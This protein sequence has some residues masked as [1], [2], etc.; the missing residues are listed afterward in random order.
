MKRRNLP[1]ASVVAGPWGSHSLLGC[2]ESRHLELR[3]RA[4]PG[5][6]VFVVEK[7]LVV[8]VSDKQESRMT[9]SH[10][11]QVLEGHLTVRRHTVRWQGS[12][13]LWASEAPGCHILCPGKMWQG[14]WRACGS[15]VPGNLHVGLGESLFLSGTASEWACWN[16]LVADTLPL[17]NEMPYWD[18]VYH[19]PSEGKFL[20]KTKICFSH[21]CHWA[22]ISENS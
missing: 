17:D 18:A 14:H 11:N 5:A 7:S 20:L 22:V 12:Q 4:Q 9:L 19:S 10:E 1:A 15:D 21:N 16:D 13:P 8:Q 2:D 6:I 3:R